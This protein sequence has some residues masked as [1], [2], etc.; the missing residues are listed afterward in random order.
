VPTR[1]EL[2]T[3]LDATSAALFSTR[4]GVHRLLLLLALL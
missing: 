3:T 4:A 2:L 1:E